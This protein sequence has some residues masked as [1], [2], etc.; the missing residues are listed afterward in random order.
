[1][2]GFCNFDLH[3]LVSRIYAHYSSRILGIFVTTIERVYGEVS[4]A[5]KS[6]EIVERKV[7]N[8]KT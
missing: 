1:M 7:S 6:S 4:T 2:E 5:R 3:Y 8:F